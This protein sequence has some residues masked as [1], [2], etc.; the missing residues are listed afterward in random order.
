MLPSETNL[1]RVGIPRVLEALQA[2][3]WD[4]LDYKTENR[5]Q[6]DFALEGEGAE[7]DSATSVAVDRLFSSFL[8][9]LEDADSPAQ[10]AEPQSS[11]ADPFGVG[12]LEHDE[13][14]RALGQ[15]K[16]LRQQAQN[17]SDSQR[18]ALAAKVALSFLSN[19]GE[20]DSDEFDD[21]DLSA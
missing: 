14:E 19:M 6:P 13:F 15:I 18:R 16:D 2:N 5:P 1:L 21:D 10:N 8:T 4:G 17:L 11:A 7:L 9:S 12:D 3:I 20:D